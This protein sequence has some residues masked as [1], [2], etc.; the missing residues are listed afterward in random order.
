MQKG[1]CMIIIGPI[2][3]MVAISMAVSEGS[4]AVF[5]VVFLGGSFVIGLMQGMAKAKIQNA[6]ATAQRRQRQH[7]DCQDVLVALAAL[8][9]FHL[10]SQAQKKQIQ[11]EIGRS[12]FSNAPFSESRARERGK[13]SSLDDA[14]DALRWLAVEHLITADEAQNIQEKIEARRLEFAQIA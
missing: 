4:L 12:T 14:E 5:F 1:E 2:L 3:F 11:A 6:Q 8:G 7:V 13:T 9:K 10:L